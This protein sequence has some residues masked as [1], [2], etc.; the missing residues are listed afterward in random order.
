M[1][2]KVQKKELYECIER[3]VIKA[4]NEA[5]E[6]NAINEAWYDDDDEDDAVARFLKDK[7]NQL[8]KRLKGAGAAK[9]AAM[10]DI[11]KE[12]DAEKHDEDV[13]ANKEKEDRATE[14]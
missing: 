7:K 3:A 11:K 6:K 10:A 9:K 5:K 12:A 1:K 8:P 13:L 2:V 14:D 4:V